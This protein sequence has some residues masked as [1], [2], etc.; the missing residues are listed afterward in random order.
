MGGR[1]VLSYLSV[2]A[3]RAG[4]HIHSFRVI[5]PRSGEHLARPRLQQAEHAKR[6]AVM[7]AA[8]T[9][10]QLEDLRPGHRPLFVSRVKSEEAGAVHQ[11]QQGSRSHSTPP[12]M[13]A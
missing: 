2:C 8:E 3:F 4:F 1:G 11:G 5:P 6:A 9:K 12:P 7:E 10:V 13:C